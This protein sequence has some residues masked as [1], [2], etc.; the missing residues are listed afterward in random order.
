MSRD[1]AAKEKNR[2]VEIS[3]FEDDDVI[4]IQVRDN[5]HPIYQ[6]IKSEIFREGV[7]S[8]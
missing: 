3:L 5:G 1:L 7:S 8:N 6:T 4:E 2:E